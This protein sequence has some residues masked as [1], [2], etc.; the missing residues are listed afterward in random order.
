[1]ELA[2]ALSVAVKVLWPALGTAVLA[3]L[4]GCVVADLV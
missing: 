4:D 3:A 1:M 2:N